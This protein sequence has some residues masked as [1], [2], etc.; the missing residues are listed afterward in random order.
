MKWNK[1][2]I[3]IGIIAI[4]YTVGIL[5]TVFYSDSLLAL[6]PINLLIGAALLFWNHKALNRNFV[7]YASVVFVAGF[8]VELAGI[9]TGKIFGQY[10]YGKNLGVMLWDVPLVIGINW[11]VLSYAT[12]CLVQPLS[13]RVSAKWQPFVLALI[14][15]LV[16]VVIDALIEPLCQRLDFWYWRGSAAPLENYTAWFMF[17]FAFNFLGFKLHVAENNQV[18]KAILLAQVIFF[19]SLNIWLV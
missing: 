12:M 1:Q 16:M 18:A 14:S 7:V 17:S 2:V 15:A 11:L 10:F 13:I 19:T 9:N 4:L 8:F 6:T 5:G 3:A